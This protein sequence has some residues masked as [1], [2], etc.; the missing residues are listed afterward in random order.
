MVYLP[1]SL[2]F[3]VFPMVQKVSQLVSSSLDMWH[4]SW[5]HQQVRHHQA[6]QVDQNYQEC[7]CLPWVLE[8]TDMK[9]NNAN[10]KRNWTD[11]KGEKTKQVTGNNQ[12]DL[13]G[14]PGTP[15]RPLS[16]FWPEGPGSPDVPL[17]RDTGESGCIQ[18][19]ESLNNKSCCC[20]LEQN[21]LGIRGCLPLPWILGIRVDRESRDFPS[22][23]WCHRYRPDREDPP[24]PGRLHVHKGSK[25]IERVCELLLFFRAVRVMMMPTHDVQIHFP[26]FVWL[27]VPITKLKIVQ[28]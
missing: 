17:S 24:D 16:P 12:L 4:D 23:P 18:T 13:P 19:L 1:F 15:G 5:T 8:D 22:L 11:G 2:M 21:L 14:N 26:M 6:L 3:D 27:T 25:V 7:H 28:I 10:R 9:W 20:F